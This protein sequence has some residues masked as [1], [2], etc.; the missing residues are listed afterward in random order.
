MQR[1][2][3]FLCG[4]Y[5]AVMLDVCF[6][7]MF[8]YVFHI[9]PYRRF[10]FCISIQ[11][12]PSFFGIGANSLHKTSVLWGGGGG[13]I[14]V[15]RRCSNPF[16]FHRCLYVLENLFMRPVT[17]RYSGALQKTL[18]ITEKEVDELKTKIQMNQDTTE[19]SV[20]YI[21]AHRTL[22]PTLSLDVA[23]GNHSESGGNVEAYDQSSCDKVSIHN[24]SIEHGVRLVDAW[25]ESPSQS[26]RRK[27]CVLW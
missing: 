8:T 10:H 13:E 4:A 27:T 17:I 16:G 26:W 24:H 7:P 15:N 2:V 22:H 25:R 3:Y 6:H 21:H 1:L 19:F 12:E 23:D 5:C 14:F 9:A 11:S 18:E 20:S